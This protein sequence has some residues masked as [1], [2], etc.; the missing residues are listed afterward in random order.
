MNRYSLSSDSRLWWLPAATAGLAASGFLAAALVVVPSGGA[1]AEPWSPWDG[2][3]G[4]AHV[5]DPGCPPPPDPDFVGVPW[6]AHSD[7]CASTHR[8]WLQ[9]RPARHCPPPP[10]PAY[11]GMPWVA[12]EAECDTLRHWWRYVH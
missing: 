8:W 11:V 9:V 12:H 5:P 3:P 6:V 10:D 2:Q 4:Y 7:E 1:T